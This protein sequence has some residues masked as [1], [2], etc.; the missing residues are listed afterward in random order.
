[1][2]PSCGSIKT[3][4]IHGEFMSLK[5][6]LRTILI[7]FVLLGGTLSGVVMR[8]EDI[9]ELLDVHNRVQAVE[10]IN[11]EQSDDGTGAEKT[12]K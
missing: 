4:P 2:P 11:N 7:G 5:G 6:R 3:T 1:M 10:C 8:P 12:A 9:E